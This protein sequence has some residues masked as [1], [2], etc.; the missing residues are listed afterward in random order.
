MTSELIE[1]FINKSESEYK[2]VR[3]HFKERASIEGIFVKG[4]DYKELKSKNFWRVVKADVA[5]E[6]AETKNIGLT[7]LYNGISFTKLS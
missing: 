4:Q 1:K 7:R 3:I 2:P 6:W 5:G